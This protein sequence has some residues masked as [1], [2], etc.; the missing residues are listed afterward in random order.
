[1]FT[2]FV[3]GSLKRG[4]SAHRLLSDQGATFLREAATH[5]RYHLVK[6]SW[7]PGM[8][9]GEEGTGVHGE[10]YELPDSA[11]KRLDRYEGVPGLFTRNEI[12]LDDGSKVVA[13][14]YAQDVSDCEIVPDGRWES[15][16]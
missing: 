9:E 16:E 5:P 11:L 14:L 7:F 6:V 10:L 4:N 13:Y 3:Y 2:L 15:G 1:M 12:E 8:V